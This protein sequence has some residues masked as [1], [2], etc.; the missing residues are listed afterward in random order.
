MRRGALA[1]A[2]RSRAARP[3]RAPCPRGGIRSAACRC[4]P[5]T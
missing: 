4:R 1:R 3:R 5:R 2:S